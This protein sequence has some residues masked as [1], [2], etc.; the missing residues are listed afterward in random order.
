MPEI[1]L[2]PIEKRNQDYLKSKINLIVLI[3]SAVMI[4]GTFLAYFLFYQ[5]QKNKENE[6]QESVKIKE[7]LEKEIK[8]LDPLG[9]KD[10][11]KNLEDIS[12]LL[13]NH[14]FFSRVLENIEH[15]TLP[16]T[17]YKKLAAS[18]ADGKVTLEASSSNLDGVAKQLVVFSKDENISEADLGKE[19]GKNSSETDGTS[20][21][22]FDLSMT[23]K[24][25]FIKGINK[26]KN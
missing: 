26:I 25:G 13:K 18:S 7:D 12:E 2:A 19:I 1:N 10:F 9:I 24:E 14:I 4:T 16:D 23:Y 20:G 22:V 5:R 17:W 21:I 11:Q 3:L 6:Y 15:N 8:I